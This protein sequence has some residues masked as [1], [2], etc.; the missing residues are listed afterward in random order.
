M[1]KQHQPPVDD[2]HGKFVSI[3]AG[4]FYED[5]ILYALDENGDIFVYTQEGGSLFSGKSVMVW[6][7]I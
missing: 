2:A 3:A 1:T 6:R 4:T 7:K 5:H